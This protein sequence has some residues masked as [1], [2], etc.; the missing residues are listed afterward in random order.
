MIGISSNATMH[1]RRALKR[2]L[3]PRDERTREQPPAVYGGWWGPNCPD[4][5][6]PTGRRH[7]PGCTYGPHQVERRAARAQQA[8]HGRDET[9]S[10]KEQTE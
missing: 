8:T 9:L 5:E 1:R 2:K 10:N 3:T 7:R 6:A 4:C